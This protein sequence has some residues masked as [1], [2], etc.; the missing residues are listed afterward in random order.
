MCLL[1]PPV[2]AHSFELRVFGVVQASAATQ[3]HS[4]VGGGWVG[5]IA[6]PE[7]PDM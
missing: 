2:H 4:L 5:G 1:A 3:N 7:K 6:V